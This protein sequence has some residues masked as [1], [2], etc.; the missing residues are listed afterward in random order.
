[1]LLLS[2]S[3]RGY[4]TLTRPSGLRYPL[5][6]PVEFHRIEIPIDALILGALRELLEVLSL[7]LRYPVGERNGSRT[8]QTKRAAFGLE[9]GVYR[10]VKIAHSLPILLARLAQFDIVNLAVIRQR[11]LD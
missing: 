11:F 4:K 9:N 8:I 1:M 10:F 2:S 3:G 7:A 6:K 5:K